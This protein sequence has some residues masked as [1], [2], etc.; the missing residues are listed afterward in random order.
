MGGHRPGFFAVP[1][2]DTAAM[3]PYWLADA[4]LSIGN[5][6]NTA[7]MLSM[8]EGLHVPAPQLLGSQ[9]QFLLEATSRSLAALAALRQN[10]MSTNPAAE[11]AIRA[12]AGHLAAAQT[13]AM[14][15][16]RAT[17]SGIVG[18]AFG[19]PV[20][21]TL[22]H[23]LAAEQAMIDVGRAFDAPEFATAGACVG[24]GA[25]MGDGGAGEAP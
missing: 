8:E 17:R 3:V 23:L 14:Q 5:A 6:A 24:G 1:S 22:A 20:R 18:P 25:A 21:S 10:A 16:V 9:A 7:D 19:V 4:S 12:A 2:G 11:P 13:Q 15:V